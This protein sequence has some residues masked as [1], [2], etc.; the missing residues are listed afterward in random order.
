[1]SRYSRVPVVAGL[2]LALA[3]GLLG[4][5]KAPTAAWASELP[6]HFAKQPVE[7]ATY[8]RGATMRMVVQAESTNGGYLTYQWM[9]GTKASMSDGVPVGEA[10]NGSDKKAV[11]VATSLN[12]PGTYFYWVTVTNHLGDDATDVNS[13]LSTITV[14]DRQLEPKL[15]N[16]DFQDYRHIP[17]SG[18]VNSEYF[19]AT[20]DQNGHI[21]APNKYTTERVTDSD[22]KTI[23]TGGAAKQLYYWVPSETASRDYYWRTTDSWG[24]FQIFPK[25]AERNNTSAVDDKGTTDTSDDILDWYH[26]V[27]PSFTPD[28]TPD[29]TTAQQ[30]N[31]TN[32]LVEL[33]C[34]HTSTIY[35]DV[36]TQPGTVYEWSFDHVRRHADTTREVVAVVIG[37]SIDS[38]SDYVANNYPTNRWNYTNGAYADY[39]S[40]EL[41]YVGS[42]RYGRDDSTLF[43]DVAAASGIDAAYLAAHPEIVGKPQSV[44]YG[45]RQW[46]VTF[47]DTG[48]LEQGAHKTYS[49]AYSVPRGQGNTVFGFVG[50]LPSGA[51]E[52]QLDNIAFALGEPPEKGQ[53]GS[54]DG[55]SKLDVTT[56]AGYAYALAEVRGS[57]VYKV[58]G[59]SSTFT[60][61]GGSASAISPNTSLGDTQSWF[62]PNAAGKLTFGNLVPGK[63]YRVIGI[64]AVTVDA[65]MGTNQSPADVLDDR[66]YTDVTIKAASSGDDQDAPNISASVVDGKGRVTLGATDSRS[67]YALLLDSGAGETTDPA[68]YTPVGDDPWRAGTGGELVWDDLTPGAT[69]RVIARV[70]GY[71]EV[72]WQSAVSTADDSSLLT[73]TVPQPGTDVTA[74]QVSRTKSGDTDT[75]NVTGLDPATQYYLYD[76]AGALVY[77]PALGTDTIVKSGLDRAKAYQ[78][79]AEVSGTL[80]EGVRVY[81]FGAEPTV[82]HATESLKV[83]DGL[84]YWIATDE[85]QPAAL[86][87]SAD[88]WQAAQTAAVPLGTPL[89]SAVDG[90]AVLDTLAARSVASMTVHYRLAKPSGYSGDYV[91]P[92]ATV[93]VGGRP[94]GPVEGSDFQVDPAAETVTP[95]VGLQYLGTNGW[96]DVPGDGLAFAQLGWDQ[97]S[98]RTVY[99]RSV[100]SDANFGSKSA[101]YTIGARPTGPEQVW[102]QFSTEDNSFTVHGLDPAT[103]YEYSVDQTQWQPL[104]HSADTAVLSDN[105]S[106]YYVRYAAVARTA[107][108]E[109]VPATPDVPASWPV[110]VSD[111]PLGL[112]SLVFNSQPY[113]QAVPSPQAVSIR[114]KAASP[115]DQFASDVTLSVVDTL[116]DGEAYGASAFLVDG[117]GEQATKELRVLQPQETYAGLFHIAVA[118]GLPVGTYTATL[119]LEYDDGVASNNQGAAKDVAE[120]MLAFTVTGAPWPEPD[121][122]ARQFAVNGKDITVSATASN[123]DAVFEY[124]LDAVSWTKAVDGQATLTGDNFAQSYSVYL[125]AAADDNHPAGDPVLLAD[126]VWTDLPAPTAVFGDGGV[127]R[128]NY[129][130]ETLELQKGYSPDDYQIT[131]DQT[132]VAANDNTFGD[133]V[134]ASQA[135]PVPVALVARGVAGADADPTIGPGSSA[136]TADSVPGRPAAPAADKFTTVPASVKTDANGS[137]VNADNTAFEYR[138]AGSSGAWTSAPSGK[139]VAVSVGNYDV[140]YPALTTAFASRSLGGVKVLAQT[141]QVSWSL[142]EAGDAKDTQIVK[143]VDMSDENLKE[144]TSGDQVTQLHVVKISAETGSLGEGAFYNWQWSVNGVAD[145]AQSGT[146][147]SGESS[148]TTPPLEDDAAVLVAVASYKPRSV[149]YDPNGGAG[150][151]EASSNTL[152]DP[153]Y[154]VTLRGLDLGDGGTAFTRDG[155][156][157]TGWNTQADGLG[158]AYQPGDDFTMTVGSQTLYAQWQE[159]VSPTPPTTDPTSGPTSDPTGGG[160]PTGPGTSTPTATA[161]STPTGGTGQPT[162][163][164]TTT[165]SSGGGQPGGGSGSGGGATSVPG[166]TSGG[167]GSGGATAGPS[168]VQSDAPS[169]ASSNP[170][171]ADGGGGAAGAGAGAG[172]TANEGG[173]L[174]PTPPTR[175]VWATKIRLAQAQVR[176]QPK[177][178]LKAVGLVVDL[179]GQVALGS[180]QVTWTSSKAKIV[181]VDAKTGKLTAG[182]K[183]GKAVVYATAVTPGATGGQVVA[184]LKVT[185]AKKKIAVKAVKAKLPKKLKVHKTVQLKAKFSPKLP[186]GV[187]VAFKVNK[188]KLAKIDKAGLLTALKPGKVKVTL[189]AGH[190]RKVYTVRI[191]K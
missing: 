71:D 54:F 87:G 47:A 162:G 19:V 172:A 185:V 34:W 101:T 132:P 88:N 147:N 103:A 191:V 11:L 91:A 33:S 141:Y 167:S 73:V 10:L 15:M 79:R 53:T 7:E 37:P 14:V 155:Y 164:P 95:S 50:I 35:Q 137:I 99:L 179:G 111:F 94:D 43:R 123:I 129:P 149:S 97:Y 105:V 66:Y 24:A 62:T 26:D 135:D 21:Y 165:A 177:K 42:Q 31:T 17:I 57:A 61:T 143:G 126:R 8:S 184:K 63:T 190:K 12:A 106:I 119:R 156:R 168:S 83:A 125:R 84:E 5:V 158:D 113:G 92:E 72:T 59:F 1:M 85:S 181:K 29:W 154:V 46:Q 112:Y 89:A 18:L 32:Y 58:T 127:L 183:P 107:G 159:D 22:G 139:A 186:T 124:S 69:Y 130:D 173:N 118:D 145:P 78:V 93:S 3:F 60:P 163:Q 170:G 16:G 6:V 189:K 27:D 80:T 109:G 49:G 38:A 40:Q 148:Y 178:K 157:F 128:V 44:T 161:T 74:A 134:T 102:G 115:T 110:K 23:N 160:T 96:T 171:T 68:R 13:S 75:I 51:S 39:R 166:P 9:R 65:T 182:K 104:E 180:Q 121:I 176:L 138:V 188:T 86:V 175:L 153:D 152:D 114:N 136:P 30:N 77:K 82:Q 146:T 142:T 108:S 140:R 144:I 36:A 187:E 100:P 28:A 56:K 52:N 2:V 90:K 116:K 120:A 70:Y 64:P 133:L 4:W 81:P 20:F 41:S 98:S 150:A 174:T 45:K 25:P 67:E 151:L 117:V 55:D 169:A 76:A 48:A 122:T 131:V